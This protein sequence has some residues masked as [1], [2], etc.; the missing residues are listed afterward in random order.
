MLHVASWWRQSPSHTDELP[1]ICTH[2]M[3]ASSSW[4]QTYSKV[5]ISKWRRWGQ[6]KTWAA[7]TALKKA[8]N[9]TWQT[10]KI[11]VHINISAEVYTYLRCQ[12]GVGMYSEL[13][14]ACITSSP[15][16]AQSCSDVLLQRFNLRSSWARSVQAMSERREEWW[17][18]GGRR[19]AVFSADSRAVHAPAL[20]CSALGT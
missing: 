13:F 14:Y 9:H 16:S 8:C 3:S 18:S 10:T 19:R 2:Y 1:T 17:W 7:T 15:R 6:N 5:Q 12:Q 11:S 4:Q 20:N